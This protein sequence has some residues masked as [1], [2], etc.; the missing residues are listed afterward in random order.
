MM[1]LKF[2]KTMVLLNNCHT[3]EHAYNIELIKTK[4]SMKSP[5]NP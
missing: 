3:S 5:S 1:L 2:F 4:Q